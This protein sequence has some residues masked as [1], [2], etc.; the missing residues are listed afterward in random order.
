MH[1]VKKRCGIS[2]VA[3]APGFRS[4]HIPGRAIDIGNFDNTT[5]T[6]GG[7]YND[8]FK[9]YDMYWLGTKDDVHYNYKA[10]KISKNL[11]IKRE[12]K[13]F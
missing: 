11:L 13:I 9:Q 12:M 1:C 10:G 5:S 8:V 2:I 7:K 4:N 3:G 6:Y